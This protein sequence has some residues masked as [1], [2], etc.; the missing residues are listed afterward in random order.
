MLMAIYG[1][2]ELYLKC[3][4]AARGYQRTEDQIDDDL[5]FGKITS[6]TGLKQGCPLCTQLFSLYTNDIVEDL[7]MHLT[8]EE[9]RLLYMLL[10]ADDMVLL[11]ESAETIEKLVKGLEV[12]TNKWGLKVNLSKTKI[13]LFRKQNDDVTTLLRE[14]K[15]HD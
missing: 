14:F 10:F 8:V 4:K 7:G 13:I 2:V 12:Y 5:D 15:F 11:S 3:Q 1:K 9:R 6:K